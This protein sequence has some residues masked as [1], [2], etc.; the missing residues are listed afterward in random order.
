MEFADNCD[1]D[2]DLQQISGIAP[3]DCGYD[4][5]RSITATDN[6]GN[7]ISFSQVVHIRDTTNPTIV[8]APDATIEVSCDGPMPTL[9]VVFADNCD[10]DL[11]ITDGSSTETLDCGA[12]ITRWV[13]ATDDCGNAITFTQTVN[14]VDE[15]APYIVSAP[16]EEIWGNVIK[17]FLLL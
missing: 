6:C 13:T 12:T 17:T 8:S 2:L 16:E 4:I 14:V 10:Q 7:A 11:T 1:A 5:S 9:E 3:M 15:T